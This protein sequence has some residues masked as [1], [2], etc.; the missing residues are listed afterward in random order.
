MCR[1]GKSHQL[2]HGRSYVTQAS[3]ALDTG[4]RLLCNMDKGYRID[5]VGSNRVSLFID[6]I[7]S[8]SMVGS[9]QDL[10]AAFKDHGNYLT[11]AAIHCF[12]SF[13]CGVK[14]TCSC[15]STPAMPTSAGRTCR[16]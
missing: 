6:H 4:G 10:T 11:Y 3:A 5:G 1:Y 9:Q 7:I 13:H 15:A 2:K 8:I 12:N 14:H 16:R